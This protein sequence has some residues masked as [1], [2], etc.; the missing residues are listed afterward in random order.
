MRSGST[1]RAEPSLRRWLASAAASA[2]RIADEPRWWLPGGLA[3]LTTIGWIPFVAAVVRPPSVAELT[4]L[5]SGLWTSGLW[6]L[7]L[8]LLA[9]AAVALVVVALA[10]A[11]AGT[12]VLVAGAE[13]REASAKDVGGIL[14]L[15]LLGAA[16]VALSV[17]TIAV[18]IVAIGPAEFNRP[19]AEAG[20]VLRVLAR[21]APLL[22]FGAIVAIAASTLAGLAGRAA[23]RTGSVAS[24]V[25]EVPAS[26]RRAGRAG[27]WHLA[28]SVAIGIGF[29]VLA[30]LL[31]AVLWAPIRSALENRAPLDLAG[32]LLLVGF[33]AIWLCLVL[34]GGAIHA[35]AS[36]T[37]TDLLGGRPASDVAERPQE[38]LIDR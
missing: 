35:W 1:P 31:L 16:P 24:A 10:L 27:L 5:G 2:R 12:A 29:L 32:V 11:A 7:N 22:V 26:A 36:M 19:G 17:L 33:V 14:V 25:A 18:A 15:S 34:A 9:A 8:V 20:P 23:V 28:V 30:G 37:A 6:P 21:L 38:T 3:W 4:Y 13:G